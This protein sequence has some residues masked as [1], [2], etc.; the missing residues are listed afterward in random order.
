[1][2]SQ[3][4]STP[5]SRHLRGR[6]KVDT[7]PELMLRRALHAKGARFRLHRTLAKN[8]TPDIVLPGRRIAVFVDGDY[9]HGC[10]AHGRKTPITGPN[11]HLWTAKFRRT[12]ERDRQATQ[13]AEEL[14]WAAV[15]VWECSVRADAPSVAQAV[16]Q[17]RTVPP[18]RV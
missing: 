4:V 14:G 10:P 2:A 16:L 18:A 9:W 3:W 6:R 17:G 11:A 15:R 7:E 13:R 5:R 1:M 12:A 8:C